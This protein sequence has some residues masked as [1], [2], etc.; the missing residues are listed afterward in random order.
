MD[1]GRLDGTLGALVAAD[2]VELLADASTPPVCDVEILVF[3][4]EEGVRLE[5]AASA[6]ARLPV[7]YLRASFGGSMLTA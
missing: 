2:C 4:D 7:G 1:G 5:P 3:A 6:A